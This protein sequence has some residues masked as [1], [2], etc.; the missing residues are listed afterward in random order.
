MSTRAAARERTREQILRAAI[1]RLADQRYDD[2]TLGAVAEAAGVT[3]QT[4]LNHFGSKE[5]MVAAAAGFFADEVP[6]LRGAVEPGDIR[7]AIGALLRQYEVMGD[8][9]WRLTA[10]AERHAVLGTLVEG[11][12]TQHRAWLES[13]FAPLLPEPGRDRDDA[14]AALYA[15]TD[16]GTWKLLRRDLGHTAEQTQA[17]LVRLTEALHGGDRS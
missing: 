5:G 16:V 9:N 11:A 6:D 13:T 8:A 1:E 3:V 10:D 4:V 7:G 14:L 2:V 12:R 17:V 15:I